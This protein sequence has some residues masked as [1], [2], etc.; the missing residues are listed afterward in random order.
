MYTETFPNRGCIEPWQTKEQN[1]VDFVER[2]ESK[3]TNIQKP[4]TRTEF[5]KFCRV[6]L[7]HS[8]S[9]AGWFASVKRNPWACSCQRVFPTYF[10]RSGFTSFA[11][12]LRIPPFRA[13][14]G[15]IADDNSSGNLGAATI[16]LLEHC[17]SPYD[18]C[19]RCY[20]SNVK[21]FQVLNP[22][23][24]SGRERVFKN[25]TSS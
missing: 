21:S 23:S 25:A 18:T 5:P 10:T 24:R 14:A 22:G 11:I 9:R 8:R 6:G 7:H 15:S 13:H 16:N 12:S 1:A 4:M 2:Q 17:I 19:V 3:S 20:S